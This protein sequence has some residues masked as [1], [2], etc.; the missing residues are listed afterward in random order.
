MAAPASTA[1]GVLLPGITEGDQARA[2]RLPP[3]ALSDAEALRIRS[4]VADLDHLLPTFD[5]R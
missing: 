5:V 4:I 3:V 2:A 1:G